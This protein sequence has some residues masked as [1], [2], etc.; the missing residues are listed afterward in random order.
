MDRSIGCRLIVAATVSAGLGRNDD[1][2][3]LC[4]YNRCVTRIRFLLEDGAS[5][6]KIPA[7]DHRHTRLDELS[8]LQ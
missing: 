5:L 8:L 6:G 7:N 1:G 3:I 4:I 2:V